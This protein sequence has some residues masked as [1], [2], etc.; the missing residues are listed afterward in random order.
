MMKKTKTALIT[1]LAMACLWPGVSS[2]GPGISYQIGEDQAWYYD[3]GGGQA[4]E[5]GLNPAAKTFLRSGVDISASYSCGEF[6]LFASMS[7]QF[8]DIKN[9][10]KSKLVNTAKGAIAALPMY[11]LQRAAPG[12]YELL[13]GFSQ[14][15]SLAHDLAEKTC[16]EFEADILAGKDP[17][18]DYM[19]AAIGRSWKKETATERDAV[20]A[21]EEVADNAG[22]EGVMMPNIDTGA[23]EAMGGKNQ[24]PIRPIYTAAGSGWNVLMDREPA[25]NTAFTPAAP[26]AGRPDPRLPALFASPGEAGEYAQQVLGDKRIMTC[27]DCSKDKKKG[28]IGRGLVK[29]VEE[30]YEDIATAMEKILATTDTPSAADLAEISAPGVGVSPE[31]ID[32]LR[33]MPQH[34][35]ALLAGKLANEAAVARAVEK[36]LAL[37]RMLAA[38]LTIPE[39]A[40]TEATPAQI[41]EA[42]GRI[43]KDIEFFLYERRI[44]REIAS[45][46]PGFII[47]ERNQRRSAPVWPSLPGPAPDPFAP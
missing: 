37:R 23:V 13:Q 19:Q 12:L 27:K 36:G 1:I 24:Q 32:E 8:A 5:V 45:A 30:E 33:R 20:A 14:D 28:V 47:A 44:R 9:N 41:N 11:I 4:V 29:K 26:V 31:I 38:A 39:I 34:K 25:D 43:E 2:A 22:D 10:V 46:T 7:N 40:D 3:L 6:D 35:A 16:E 21:K 15:F 42:I 17:Y 18:A